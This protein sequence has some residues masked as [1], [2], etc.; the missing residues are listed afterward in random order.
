MNKNL[1]VLDLLLRWRQAIEKAI[2]NCEGT[3]RGG[4]FFGD[5]HTGRP[6]ADIDFDHDGRRFQITVKEIERHDTAGEP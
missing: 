6:V 3:R 5:D 2:D 4:G 1:D